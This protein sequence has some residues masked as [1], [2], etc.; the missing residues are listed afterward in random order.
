MPRLAWIGWPYFAQGLPAG[1]YAYRHIPLGPTEVLTW[2]DIT[3]RFGGIP[4]LVLYADCSQPPPLLDVE[5]YPCPTVFCCIDSHIHSWYPA[6]AQAFDLCTVSLRD[7]LSRFQGRLGPERLL[8][9][10]PMARA[11][12][13]EQAFVP[14]ADKAFDLL[15]VGKVDPATTPG[16]VRFLDALGAVFPGL[17]VRQGN[18]RTLF[19]QARLVLNVAEG[20]DLNFRVFEA[21]ACGACLLTP[22]VGHGQETLLRHGEHLFVYPAEDAAALRKLAE[23]LLADPER[24]AAVARRGYEAVRRLHG[25]LQRGR[26]FADWLTGQPLA[27]LVTERLAQRRA[28]RQDALRLLYLHWA[29]ALSGDLR[30]VSYLKAVRSWA[31]EA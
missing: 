12:P 27:R 13:E 17:A 19:P 16:R 25:P 24:R 11:L 7:H 29:E 8:W 20:G 31:R 23:G 14:E 4:D 9:L 6:W 10:P 2:A 3:H 18:F 21:L 30:A 22:A 1:E 5:S 28:I 15:F 26:T